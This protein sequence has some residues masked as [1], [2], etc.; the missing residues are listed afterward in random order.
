MAV[1]SPNGGESWSAGSKQTITWSTPTSVKNV[2]I[3]FSSNFNPQNPTAAKWTKVDYVANTGSYSW[4]VP[5]S[6]SSSC[7]IRI[8]D[9][10]NNSNVD[11]SDGNFS[12][13]KEGST[14]PPS[15]SEMMVVSPNGGESWG[16]GSTQTISWTSPSSVQ[17]VN[18]FFSSN[19]NPNN[20]TAASWKKIAYT[21]N[22]GSFS[23]SVPNN[24]SSKCVIRIKDA[25]N[26]SQVDIGDANFSIVA[27]SS[28]SKKDGE[29]E[30]SRIEEIP[31][32][33]SLEQNYPNPFNPTTQIK[34]GLKKSQNVKITV[35]N[36]M[37]EEVRQLVNNQLNAGIH[38]IS[39]DAS[40]LASGVYI[41]RLISEDFTSTKRMI[42]LK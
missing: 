30:L 38:Y 5:S 4:N 17:K 13:V 34:F 36:L 15:S 27:G 42:L 26:Q 32:E 37:G 19:Y 35:Y 41:Y 40:G 39:F 33:Y 25:F 1:V 23:W 28:I 12:I 8:K 7:V 16:V 11:I 2:N 10:A 31:D 21:N 24:V 29:S 3:F 14:P 9:G 20:P 22:D 18:I 6:L